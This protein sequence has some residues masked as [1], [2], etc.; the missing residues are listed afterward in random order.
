MTIGAK[1][2][3][4]LVA[5][6]GWLA[7]TAASAC[8]CV[9][10]P[11]RLAPT[12]VRQALS[13]ADAVFEGTVRAVRVRGDL[14]VAVFSVHRQWRGEL[15]ARVTVE[16]AR[17]LPECGIRFRLGSKHVV[18]AHGDSDGVLHA[19]SCSLT[20]RSADAGPLIAVLGEAEH[21]PATRGCALGDPGTPGLL[22]VGLVWWRRRRRSRHARA[23]W[24]K[25]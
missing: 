19:S 13:R 5:V 11:D 25:S 14:R 20:T 9:F 16:S 4:V 22:L 17:H 2:V 8:G 23:L 12:Y 1:G 15:G 24:P 3:L 10:V 21:P 6:C 7:P 18:F